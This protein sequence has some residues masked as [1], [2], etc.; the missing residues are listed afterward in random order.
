MIGMP[1]WPRGFRRGGQEPADGTRGSPH[2]VGSVSRP[3]GREPNRS[4]PVRCGRWSGTDG[5]R[6]GTARRGSCSLL[7]T[8]QSQQL[9]YGHDDPPTDANGRKVTAL[10]SGIGGRTT[11]AD[12]STSLRDI[13]DGAAPEVRERDGRWR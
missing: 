8:E 5:N 12:E 3:K 1:S 11:E 2:S 9:G 10:S 6:F 13:Q 4:P 7:H